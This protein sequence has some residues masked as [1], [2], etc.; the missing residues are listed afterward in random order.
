MIMT[1]SDKALIISMYNNKKRTD[2]IIRMLPYTESEARRYIRELRQQGLLKRE[3]KA[4][5][6]PQQL[7][8]LQAYNDGLI[9]VAE[10]AEEIG[11]N[12]QSVRNALSAL[13]LSCKRPK[14][15]YKQRP[16]FSFAELSKK[17]QQIITAI[18]DGK[19]GGDICLQFNISRQYLSEVKKKYLRSE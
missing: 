13:G 12:E 9:T 2:D 16:R 3:N 19:A 11:G 1:E 4:T 14:H 15:N 17:T 7:A 18:Q 10:I 6:S 8:V 5:E